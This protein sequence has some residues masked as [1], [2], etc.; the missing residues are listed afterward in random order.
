MCVSCMFYV[1]WELGERK[2]FRVGNLNLNKN[3]LGW[4]TG[5]NQLFLRPYAACG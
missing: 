4:V 5:N 3:L 1:D 2:N